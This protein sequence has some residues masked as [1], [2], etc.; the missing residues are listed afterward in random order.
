MSIDVY[1]RLHC[2]TTI[3]IYLRYCPGQ[4]DLEDD[5]TKTKN[6]GERKA[7]KIISY[8]IVS[9]RKYKNALETVQNKLNTDETVTRK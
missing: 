7:M 3:L 6:I 4:T 1:R 8:N 9:L 5:K 2:I